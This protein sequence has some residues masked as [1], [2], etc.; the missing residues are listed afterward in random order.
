MRKDWRAFWRGRNIV[1]LIAV[2]SIS[3]YTEEVFVNGH[4][5]GRNMVEKGRVT[6]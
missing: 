3:V 2:L 5:S 4:G 1:I 6:A